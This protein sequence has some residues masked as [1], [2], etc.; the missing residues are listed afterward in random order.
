M[1]FIFGGYSHDV[2]SVA[3]TSVKRNYVDGPTG[4]HSFLRVQWALKGK[5]LGSSM[6]EIM[7]KLMNMQVAYTSG[8]QSAWMNDNRGA[9]I[10]AFWLDDTQ[11][12]G[13][14]TVTEPI[15]HDAIQGAEGVLYLKY[16]FAL[17]ADFLAPKTLLS[18][19]ETV[20]FNDLNGGPMQVERIPIQGYP[21][22]QN[23]TERSFYYAT[24]SGSLTQNRSGPI[25]SRPLWP[26]NLKGQIGAKQITLL[27]VK[28]TRGRGIE[29]GISWSYNFVSSSPLFGLNQVHG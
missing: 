4:R 16:K 1:Q 9:R 2:N 21:I 18:F 27:P 12:I 17:Q 13:G 22:I 11:A 24:Q 6:S 5:L 28:T 3:F 7:S 25:A 23:V 15:S 10:P 20:S 8:G 14:V 26:G 19:Q 29:Y